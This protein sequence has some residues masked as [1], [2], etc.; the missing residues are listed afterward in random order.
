MSQRSQVSGVTPQLPSFSITKTTYRLFEGVLVFVF[1]NRMFIQKSSKKSYGYFC[2]VI[3]IC[4]TI[5]WVDPDRD[6]YADCFFG[7]F[8]LIGWQIYSRKLS[9]PVS[10]EKFQSFFVSDAFFSSFF[11]TAEDASVDGVEQVP[12]KKNS[13]CSAFFKLKM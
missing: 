5:C 13:Q 1:F 9:F 3:F 11:L 6:L 8:R 4:G 7:L 2:N 10:N 12:A